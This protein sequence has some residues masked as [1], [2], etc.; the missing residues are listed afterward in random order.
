MYSSK[1][2]LDKK[3]YEENI[4]F[5]KKIIGEKTIIS[6]VVKGNAYGHGIKE[7]ILLAEE[8]GINHFSVFSQDEAYKVK[9][10]STKNSTIMIMGVLSLKKINWVISNDIEFF[11]FNFKRLKEA[12]KTS[13]KLNKKIKIHI[14]V[15]TGLNRT[16]FSEKEL[17]ELFKIIQKN[18]E[19]ITI[20][21]ICTHFAGAESIANYYRIK[22][23]NNRFKKYLE[24]FDKA[25]IKYELTHAACS[26]AAVT[27]PN[28]RRNL[29]RIGIM[30]YGFWPSDETRMF[31]L[32]KKQKKKDPLQPILSWESEIMSIKH[33]KAG[34]YIG[35]GD[36]YLAKEDMTIGTVP[37]GYAQG[38]GRQ[39]SNNSWIMV[40]D[41][42]AEVIGVI[43]MNLFQINI[44]G[45]ENV[46]IGDRVILI[47]QENNK[48]IR[49]AS[50]SDK[51]SSLN[52]EILT[53]IPEELPREIINK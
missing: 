4:R 2:Y 30:Q 22:K 16:G 10:Y 5:I 46:N 32:T 8:S 19:Y 26:A 39:L 25:N 14:E 13:K 23:Q 31:Y 50:F 48:E 9:K 3:K 1:I 20:K 28:T 45:L 52:Y 17:P 34:E 29:V 27:M 15:E 53:R 37:I 6:S 24:E 42:I 12:L 43:N 47:G 11:V 44:S 38:Y 49:F 36:Y 41:E 35:Y 21:G 33:V 7:M 51:K 40:N 18:K